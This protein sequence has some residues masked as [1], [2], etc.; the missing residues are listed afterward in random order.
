MNWLRIL[1]W[2]CHN[3]WFC[4]IRPWQHCRWAHLEE[5]LVCRHHRR[6]LDNQWWWCLHVCS[7]RWVFDT[8]SYSD[9]FRMPSLLWEKF[10]RYSVNFLHDMSYGFFSL[11]IWFLI[12]MLF[13]CMFSTCQ[14]VNLKGY[15]SY[16]HLVLLYLACFSMHHV[17]LAFY[18]LIVAVVPECHY[19][20][21]WIC[22]CCLQVL[23]SWHYVFQRC[24]LGAV[25]L[26]YL[27]NVCRINTVLY[28]SISWT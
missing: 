7:V 17:C 26:V 8:Q 4:I 16:L 10:R 25:G 27:V 20:P 21:F 28:I 22:F 11:I 1:R 12:C 23:F 5:K 6:E 13:F 18:W 2:D 3:L 19:C 14:G 9:S 15:I 24:L